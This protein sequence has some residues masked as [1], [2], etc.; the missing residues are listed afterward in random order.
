MSTPPSV[1]AFFPHD[2]CHERSQHRNDSTLQSDTCIRFGIY[3]NGAGCF[4]NMISILFSLL[5]ESKRPEVL[6]DYSRTAVLEFEP[7][8][9]AVLPKHLSINSEN[10]K[11]IICKFIFTSNIFFGDS[12]GSSKKISVYIHD[13]KDAVLKMSS[14]GTM[15]STEP[16]T[17]GLTIESSSST[18]GIVSQNIPTHLCSDH[19][20]EIPKTT[21]SYRIDL[22]SKDFFEILFAVQKLS[23][24][25]TFQVDNDSMII[26]S[27]PKR[28][29]FSK[30]IHFT[31]PRKSTNES[32]NVVI[33]TIVNNYN[34]D[35]LM[36]L[37]DSVKLSHNIQLLI[38]EDFYL[39]ISIKTQIGHMFVLFSPEK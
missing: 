23:H 28:E 19:K 29:G 32:Q 3:E 39:T 11:S 18:G 27:G 8:A 2:V 4:K 5:C 26:S 37:K 14:T 16:D 36:K 25:V 15:F 9:T 6:S 7:R 24:I 10:P 22:C 17:Y 13:L 21:Y 38:K 12:F 31:S 20:F 33:G 34:I 35:D 1:D 30:K